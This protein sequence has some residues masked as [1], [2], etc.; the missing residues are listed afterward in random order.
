MSDEATRK[1]RGRPPK[2]L[3]DAARGPLTIRLRADVRAD[4][5]RASV[6]Y[7]RSLSE[8]I[9]SR[10]EISFALKQ[11][12]R[13]EIGED[14]F[15]LANAM[16]SSLSYLEGFTGKEWTEDQ[17][18]FETFQATMANLLRN[19]RDLKIKAE[20]RTFPVGDF[21]GKSTDERGQMLAGLGGLAP[22]RPRKPAAPAE[23]SDEQREGRA[24]SM[25]SMRAILSDDSSDDEGES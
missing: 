4:V 17:Q 9:E 8:E 18:T 6:R 19:Y 1:R 2:P 22:P 23:P 3:G 14:I 13:H 5:E 24:R 15:C 7:G 20:G 11:Y 12:F 25:A 10:L 21:E 16:A